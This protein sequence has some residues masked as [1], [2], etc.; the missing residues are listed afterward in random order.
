MIK[1][2]TI[3]LLLLVISVSLPTRAQHLAINN[4]LLFDLTGAFSA[5][6]EIPYLKSNTIELYGSIRPW[7]RGD[8]QVH[9]HWTVQAQYRLW[10]CQV[11]NGFFWGPYVHGGQF[12][13]GNETLFFGLLKGLKPSRYE[14]WFLGGGMGAGYEYPLAKHW[15][16]GAEIGVGYTYI[17]YKKYACEKCGA[18]KDNG[19]YHYL[20]VSRLGLS[21]IY[22]F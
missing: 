3:L 14:G 8:Q 12:N 10:P 2:T 19:V 17:D 16:V 6:V 20:G 15:N 11:M 4:N 18:L 1:K 13:L 7:K 5:G 9:K 21:I 22:V